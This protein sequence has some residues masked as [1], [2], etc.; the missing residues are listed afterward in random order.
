MDISHNWTQE[1]RRKVA[2]YLV[3][4]ARN[5]ASRFPI[6]KEEQ[7]DIWQLLENVGHLL[8][9]GEFVLESRRDDILKYYKE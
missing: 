2:S 7:L 9:S 3:F 5:K 4:R 6:T 8:S 1:E